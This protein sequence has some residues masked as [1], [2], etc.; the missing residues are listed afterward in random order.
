[1]SAKVIVE[2]EFTERIGLCNGLHQGFTMAP[3]LLSLYFAVVV[4]DWRSKCSVAG[5]EFRYKYGCKLVGD[6][7]IKSLD[8]SLI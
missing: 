6:R 8:Y 3:V 2:K 4:D 1:M 7:T 5:V